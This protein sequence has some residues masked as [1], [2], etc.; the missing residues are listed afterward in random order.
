MRTRAFLAFSLASLALMVGASALAAEK[1]PTNVKVA[2]VKTV[3]VHA[4]TTGASQSFTL[5]NLNAGNCYAL[6][7]ADAKGVGTGQT[8]GVLP[9]SDIDE[10]VR[11]QLAS[12][13]PQCA[14]S[15]L[16]QTGD[17]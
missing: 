11:K 3:D 17:E 5:V 6:P 10:N 16:M 14:P 8:I 4:A 1:T 12:D 7:A 9:A 15:A 13:Y 2:S